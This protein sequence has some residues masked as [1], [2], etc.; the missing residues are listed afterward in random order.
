L[1]VMCWSADLFQR[2]TDTEARRQTARRELLEGLDE[3]SHVFLSG[4]EDVGSS[5]H[6]IL[7]FS[8]RIPLLG[9]LKGV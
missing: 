6:P 8:T 1:L 7:V 9:K 3:F 4:N 2:I 5:E